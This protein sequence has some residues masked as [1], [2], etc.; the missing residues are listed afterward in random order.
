METVTGRRVLIVGAGLAGL[1]AART[2][3]QG[4]CREITIAEGQGRPG[5]RIWTQWISD[6]L[7]SNNKIIMLFSDE[8]CLCSVVKFTRCV[9][10]CSAI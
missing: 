1:N 2:L 9:T 6:G 5:G 7:Y 3:N 10:K 4:G 8:R